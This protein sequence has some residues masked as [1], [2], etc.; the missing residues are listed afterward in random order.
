MGNMLP[1]DEHGAITCFNPAK[2]WYLNWFSW[3]H[4]EIDPRVTAFNNILVSLDDVVNNNAESDKMIVKVTGDKNEFFVMFNRAK[5]VNKEAVGYRDKVV[6]TQQNQENAISYAIAGLGEGEYW[7]F[8]NFGGTDKTLVI[9]NC[10]S[11]ASDFVKDTAKVLIYLKGFNDQSC[12]PLSTAREIGSNFP[13][14]SPTAS[15]KYSDT[16]NNDNSWYDD[17]GEKFN[18]GWYELNPNRCHWYGDGHRNFNKVANEACCV[19]GGGQSTITRDSKQITNSH[20][21]IPSVCVTDDNWHDIDGFDCK[22]YET[23]QGACKLFGHRYKNM[24]KV[25]NEACCVCQ[26]Q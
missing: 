22:W 23:T 11:S 4:I 10:N 17:G 14:V 5:G 21:S 26:N 1:W 12:S 8:D 3:R 24:K 16:C 6:V 19:C 18:C 20:A 7:S 2:T 9:Q 15:P 25:A 13:S